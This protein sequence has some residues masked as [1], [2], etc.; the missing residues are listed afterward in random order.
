MTQGAANPYQDETQKFKKKT[1]KDDRFH[2]IIIP[3]IS[4]EYKKTA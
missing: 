2:V 1:I 4:S 3:V